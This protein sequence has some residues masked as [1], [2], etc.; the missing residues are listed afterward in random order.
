V[1][2]FREEEYPKVMLHEA[3]HHTT[4]DPSPQA[5][6]GIEAFFRRTYNIAPAMRFLPGEGVVEA[7]ATYYQCKFVAADTQVPFEAMWA[8]E[9]EHMKQQAQAV[10]HRCKDERAPWFETT[11]AFAY[12][13][14]KWLCCM[15]MTELIG[16]GHL[17]VGTPMLPFFER[18]ILSAPRTSAVPT[19]PS[20][21]RLT[22]FGDL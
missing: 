14:V 2:I 22:V 21:M 5:L 17:Q 16:M 11:N 7:F 4:L 6:D 18:A 19:T 10:L 1:F 13:V 15:N 9:L 3:I 8:R 12:I 20:S